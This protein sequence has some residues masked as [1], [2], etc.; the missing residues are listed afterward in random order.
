MKNE[1]IV[2]LII[3]FKDRLYRYSLSILKNTFDAEDVIQELMIRIW[4]KKDSFIE[5]EN[6]EAWCMTVT[7]N[8]S[9]DKIRKNK[10]SSNTMDIDECF[11]ISDKDATPDEA[12]IRNDQMKNLIL[13][14]DELSENQKSVIHLRDIEGYS[15]KEISEITG[16][17]LDQV[18]INLHRGRNSLK[19]KILTRTNLRR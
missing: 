18:K 2:K 15:Y 9:I 11:S 12:A 10:K 14:I 1:D 8:L 13:L 6:K 16:L 3:P 17:S 19:E 5:I 7:R 4:K